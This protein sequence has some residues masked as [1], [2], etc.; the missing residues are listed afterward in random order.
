MGPPSDLAVEVSGLTKKFGDVAAVDRLDLAVPRGSVY[1]F[2]GPNGAGK[3]TTLRILATLIWPDSGSAFVLGH[4]VV[5][6]PESVRARVSMTGQFATIDDDLT[7]FENLVLIGRLLGLS[8]RKAKERA[9]ERL[10][11]FDLEAAGSRVV[12]N[13]SG[14]MRRR[15][16]LAASIVVTPDLLFLDEPTTGLDPRSRNQVWKIV[17]TLP[18]QGTTILL[19]TQYLEEADQLADRIAVIDAGKIVAEGTSDALKAS[20]GS[21]ALRVR[22]SDV[23]HRGQ[24]QE[25]LARTLDA[26]VRVEAETTVLITRVQEPA[27]AATALNELFHTGVKLSDFAFEQPTLDEVFFALTDRVPESSLE[28]E[29]A[30]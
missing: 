3:T 28:E 18:Q 14:G 10:E 21:G 6:D 4:D 16:D 22:V 15:L 27:R 2:L 20:V 29:E 8:R 1:G 9:I 26:P 12:K 30:A 7:G 23:R 11:S 13:L 25:I 5:R 17:R 24:A 19:T